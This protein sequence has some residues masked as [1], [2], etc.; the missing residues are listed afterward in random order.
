MSGREPGVQSRKRSFS[1]VWFWLGIGV[2]SVLGLPLLIWARLG[3][4]SRGEV[5]RELA[6]LRARGEPLT[7]AEV[8][9]K[10]VP[11]GDCRA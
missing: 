9:P 8:A 4:K 7:P 2:W 11:D 3:A 10:P 5:E 6:A 1:R